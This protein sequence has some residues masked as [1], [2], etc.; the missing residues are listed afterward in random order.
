MDAVAD[1]PPPSRHIVIRVGRRDEDHVEFSVRDSG[2]GIGADALSRIFE[3][4]FTTKT[5]NMGMGL[6]ICRTIVDAHRGEI[7]AENNSDAG[8]TVRFTLPLAQDSDE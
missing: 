1:Q 2:A 5:G 8:A 3:P 4:F 6:A 7:R